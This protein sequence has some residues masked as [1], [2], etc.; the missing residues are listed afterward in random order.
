MTYLFHH[1]PRSVA[2]GGD[3]LSIQIRLKSR[4]R[5]LAPGIRFVATPNAGK[6]TAW[7]AMKAKAEG[8]HAGWPDIT[9]LWHN[10]VGPAA[11]PG[12]AFL[13]LKARD[14]ALSVPQIDTLNWLH[15]AGFACGCFRSV[16]TAIEFLRQAGAPFMMAAAA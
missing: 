13:E 10:G 4:L 8:M 15:N 9:A 6:R 5:I 2:D 7:A 16:D 11:V 3:E 14:G 12:I 1:D